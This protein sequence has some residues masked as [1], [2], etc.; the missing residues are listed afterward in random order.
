MKFQKKKAKRSPYYGKAA[1]EAMREQMW[2]ECGKALL[3]GESTDG[4][5]AAY[6]IAA[7]PV[8]K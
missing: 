7:N 2:T 6:N 3:R 8:S 4:I 1:R 5:T